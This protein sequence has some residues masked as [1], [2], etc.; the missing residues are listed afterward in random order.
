MRRTAEPDLPPAPL[1]IY[2]ASTIGMLRR[3]FTMSME[4][5]RL[6]SLIGRE[7]FRSQVSTIREAWFEDAVIYIHDIERCLDKLHHFDQQAIARVILQGHVHE[8]AA[9]LLGCTD[10]HLR[11]RLVIAIDVL[12]QLFLDR[13][14]MVIAKPRRYDHLVDSICASV[15]TP[16]VSFR[17]K[18]DQ[19]WRELPVE[20]Y[21]QAPI[22]SQI[23]VCC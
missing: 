11:R 17:D 2:R 23:S 20:I 13:G 7:V 4:L 22:A 3:Y 18:V 19:S 6:P 10:R 16:R 1:S 8:E 12:S 5:G 14:L 9:R 15:D 21:C